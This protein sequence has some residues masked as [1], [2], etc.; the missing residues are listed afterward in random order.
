MFSTISTL[1]KLLSQ[2]NFPGLLWILT[3]WFF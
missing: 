3:E 1:Y 2:I